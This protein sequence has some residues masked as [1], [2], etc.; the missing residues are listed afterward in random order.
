MRGTAV[1]T[2][3][4]RSGTIAWWDP[5][6]GCASQVMTKK[7]AL[8]AT[9]ALAL[10]TGCAARPPVQVTPAQRTEAI[11]LYADGVTLD[12]VAARLAIGH[13]DAR[14]VIRSGLIDMQRRYAREP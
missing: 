10:A 3:T 6:G 9:L 1:E 7:P 5:L 14:Y 2:T 8:I 11:R 13:D 12:Q 4:S